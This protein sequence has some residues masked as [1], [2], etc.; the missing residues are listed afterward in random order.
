MRIWTGWNFRK[1]QPMQSV[2]E[3]P[4][5]SF[6]TAQRWHAWLA[7]NYSSSS[8]VQ[9]R[10]FKKGSGRKSV[11]YDGALDEALCYGWIDGQKNSYDENSWIQKFTPRGSKSIW[12]KRN[13]EHVARLIKEKRMKSAGLK[14]VEAAKVDGRW[15]GAYDSPKNMK[16]P[17][18]FLKE[19]R[20]DKKAHDFFKTLNRA[21]LYSI[22]WR[23]QTAKRSETRERRMKEILAMLAQGK[24]FH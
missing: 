17:G 12:S 4:I 3:L 21:N 1:Q 18:D 6:P 23:L 19:L 10:I 11:S 16:I 15:D 5:L 7:R 9:L 14:Q 13:K 20:K 24:K 22:G 8:G 2:T